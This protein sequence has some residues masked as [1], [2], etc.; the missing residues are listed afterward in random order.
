MVCLGTVDRVGNVKNGGLEGLMQWFQTDKRRNSAPARGA[1]TADGEETE[2]TAGTYRTVRTAKRTET[3][4]VR[5]TAADRQLQQE[6]RWFNDSIALYKFT[7]AP[8][9]KTKCKMYW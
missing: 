2:A 1:R 7:Q 4:H 9:K 5:N 3:Q 8:D 6:N